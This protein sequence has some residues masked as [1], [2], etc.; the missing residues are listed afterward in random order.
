MSSSMNTPCYV[1]TNVLESLIFGELP[2]RAE[3]NDIVSTLEMGAQGIVLAAETAIGKKPRLC[4]EIVRELMHKYMLSSNSLL[5][6]D[7]DR[8]EITD[9]TMKL[10]LNRSFHSTSK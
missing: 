7:L 5:F 1:A 10:W 2:T 3:L 9:P 8:D 4:V 6:G